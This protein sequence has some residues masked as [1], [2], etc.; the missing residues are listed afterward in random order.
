MSR[1]A[2]RFAPVRFDQHN[3]SVPL[4][5]NYRNNSTMSAVA[6]IQRV[7]NTSLLLPD[8]IIV[9]ERGASDTELQSEAQRLLRFFSE[10]HVRLLRKWNGIGLEVVRF[11]GCGQEANKI[12]RIAD[13]QLDAEF[14]LPGAIIVGSD[15]SGF[16]YLE[17]ENG[18]MLSY[19]TDGGTLTELANDLDDFV[20]RVVFGK[21]AAS[22][23]GD[24]WFAELEQN[25]LLSD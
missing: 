16:V 3:T 18:T 19:D 4:Y 5:L 10:K 12:G 22:F 11:F 2:R 9:P 7:L 6:T 14:G 23:A 17:S 13:L 25:G 20:D 8:L 24:D 15:A 21:D 1:G